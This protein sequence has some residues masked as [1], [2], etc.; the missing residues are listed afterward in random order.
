MY[1][2]YLV[3]CVSKLET[4]S[5]IVESPLNNEALRLKGLTLLRQYTLIIY[6]NKKIIKTMQIINL[7]SAILSR[8][9]FYLSIGPNREG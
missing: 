7:K 9:N 6:V 4:K 5:Q 1:I 8:Q 3:Q 2:K